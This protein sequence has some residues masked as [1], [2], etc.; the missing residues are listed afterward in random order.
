MDQR[1]HERLSNEAQRILKD[2]GIEAILECKICG[3]ELTLRMEIVPND[4]PILT[5][6]AYNCAYCFAMNVVWE[7]K[8]I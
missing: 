6:L 2:Q 5:K 3:A 7:K 8:P 1:D 4:Y